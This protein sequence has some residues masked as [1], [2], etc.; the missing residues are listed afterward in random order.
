MNLVLFGAAK[1]FADPDGLLE[2]EGKTGRHYKL[3]SIKDLKKPQI[4]KWLATAA[5]ASRAA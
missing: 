5:K 2:G 4:K 1:D 3:T